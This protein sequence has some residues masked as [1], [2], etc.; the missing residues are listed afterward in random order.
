MAKE[1]RFCWRDD[2]DDAGA[3]RDGDGVSTIKGSAA[4]RDTSDEDDDE[5][6][7]TLRPSL[8]TVETDAVG[9]S[10]DLFYYSHD[11]ANRSAYQYLPKV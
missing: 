5:D 11:M 3:A 4:S 8:S 9:L 7:S 2:D 6:D 10:V 1:T